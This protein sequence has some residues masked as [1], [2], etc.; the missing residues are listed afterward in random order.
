MEKNNRL[1][2]Q[3]VEI[4][5]SGGIIAYPTEAVF[6]LGCDPQNEAAIKKLLAIK[7]RNIEKGL[8]LIAA[9]IEQLAPY[10]QK[11]D[12]Q[13][14]QRILPTWPGPTTWLLPAKP[15]VSKLLRGEH[16]TIAV[17]VTNHPLAKKLCETWGNALISTSA[18][19]SNQPAVNSVEKAKIVF[20]DH[21]DYYLEGNVGNMASPTEII[22]GQ[23]GKIVR[24]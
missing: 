19:M 6:G 11:L 7:K 2:H 3:A 13:T 22:D 1:L 14:R 8:I 4:L 10:I 18:N 12:E 21:V 15:D 5:T 17:R 23:T 16:T 20:S 24:H 9:N